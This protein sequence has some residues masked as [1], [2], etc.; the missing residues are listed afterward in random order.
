[1]NCDPHAIE[2]VSVETV[3]ELRRFR[4][5][6]YTQRFPNGHVEE[7]DVIVHPGAA[8]ILPVTRDGRVV[9]VKQYRTSLNAC[10]VELPAGVFDPGESPLEA[11][12]RE[13]LEETGYRADS[14]REL[15]RSHPAPGLTDECLSIYLAE[16][17]ELGE[18][19]REP[20]EY[21]EV[22]HLEVSEVL[23]RILCG[24]ITD[25]KTQVAVLLADRLGMLKPPSQ[26]GK[27]ARSGGDRDE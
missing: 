26:V 10:H 16:G 5:A 21:L 22:L 6:R 17:L 11:A 15:T 1:M 8:V 13:L 3:A 4:L 7:R 12:R 2:T 14:W 25:G 24:A 18:A 9:L 20:G 19:A 27:A 23:E